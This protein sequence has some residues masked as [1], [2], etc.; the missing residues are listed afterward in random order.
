MKFVSSAAVVATLIA[1]SLAAA[2]YEFNEPQIMKA[3][4][5]VIEVESP[6]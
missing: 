2:D 3:D 1:S 6:G 4:G 5:K